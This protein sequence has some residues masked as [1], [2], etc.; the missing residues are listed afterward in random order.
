MKMIVLTLVT[1]SVMSCANQPKP[2]VNRDPAQTGTGSIG[3]LSADK[4]NS[5]DELTEKWNQKM[6]SITDTLKKTDDSEEEPDKTIYLEKAKR[7]RIIN[8]PKTS[9]SADALGCAPIQSSA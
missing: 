8:V 5:I 7:Q 3:S 9:T 4:I 6:E 2:E 1:L